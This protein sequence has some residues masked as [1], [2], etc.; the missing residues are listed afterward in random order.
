MAELRSHRE[1]TSFFEGAPSRPEVAVDPLETVDSET[2]EPSPPQ[3][4]KSHRSSIA[5]V[6]TIASEIAKEGHGGNK[7]VADSFVYAFDIDGVLIRG[8]KP[9][10]E[11]VEAMKVLGGDNEYGIVV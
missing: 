9:I 4:K 10:P 2:T 5:D 7:H 6:Q 11:A 3:P 8:G 1:S